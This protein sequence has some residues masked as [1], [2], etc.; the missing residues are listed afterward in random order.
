MEI[1]VT[2]V[3]A[4]DPV[5]RDTASA[6]LICDLPHAVMVRYD[7]DLEAGVL[8]RMLTTSSQRLETAQTPVQ[9]CLTCTVREDLH[10]VLVELYRSG[11]PQVV[12][13]PPVTMDPVPILHAVATAPPPAVLASSLVVLDPATFEHD[14]LG[15]DLL[16]ERTLSWGER[17]RRSVG[18][19]IARQ[20]ETA[21]LIALSALPERRAQSL[22]DHLVGAVPS[23]VPLHLMNADVF[24]RRRPRDFPHTGDLRRVE[25]TDAA[26]ANGVVTVDLRSWRPLHSERLR[27]LAVHAAGPG[28]R[29]RGS[30]WL[31]T[32][33]SAQ[34]AWDAAGAQLAIGDLARW[35]SAPETHLVVTAADR[36]PQSIRDAFEAALLDDAELAGGLE[37]WRGQ[38]DGLDEWLG[39]HTE[40]DAL[41]LDLIR[42]DD[43]RGS[44]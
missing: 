7:L 20:V 26:D 27:D 8:R 32:R 17:D 36:D 10:A 24:A 29:A 15:D 39:P 43:G 30:F 23:R 40:H 44:A 41:T 13:A 34:C 28:V 22:F 3:S 11:A 35:A 9:H 19:V 31:P 2:V 4:V 5:L 16:V 12:I 6:V 38:E 25:P 14:L 21:D 18:E 33:P 37:Q 42:D 1:P